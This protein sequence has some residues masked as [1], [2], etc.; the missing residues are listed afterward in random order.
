MRM[1]RKSYMGAV[2]WGGTLGL[3]G[4]MVWGQMMGSGHQGGY[5][6]FHHVDGVEFA[7]SPMLHS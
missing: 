2:L 5:S 6:S 3:I 1:L 7:G 4:V